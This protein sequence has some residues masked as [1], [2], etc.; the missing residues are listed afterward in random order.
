[1]QSRSMSRRSRQGQCS[2]R[3]NARNQQHASRRPREGSISDGHIGGPWGPALVTVGHQ[4]WSLVPA[5]APAACSSADSA[6][7]SCYCCC[8]ST[9]CCLLHTVGPRTLSIATPLWPPTALRPSCW[10]ELHLSP[11]VGESSSQMTRQTN[12]TRPRSGAIRPPSYPFLGDAP[13]VTSDVTIASILESTPDPNS[14]PPNSSPCICRCMAGKWFDK[15]SFAYPGTD[16][17]VPAL[18]SP[19]PWATS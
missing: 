14:G 8:D 18:S 16:D 2:S 9:Q 12:D 11:D 1:M 4:G 5:Q 15:F 7:Y 17:T 3:R 10:P 13:S 19:P 6:S